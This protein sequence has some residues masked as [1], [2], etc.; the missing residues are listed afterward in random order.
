MQ[1]NYTTVWAMKLSDLVSKPLG[2]IM[3]T[4]GRVEKGMGAAEKKTQDVGKALG[5]AG[6]AANKLEAEYR[7]T[8]KAMRE[9]MDPAKVAAMQRKLEALGQAMG[10]VKDKAQG[11]R[12]RQELEAG[13]MS[14][15]GLARHMRH[16]QQAR[17]RAFDP[18]RIRAYNAELRQTQRLID[19]RNRMYGNGGG[20]GRMLAQ[21]MIQGQLYRAG[22][23]GQFAGQALFGGGAVTTGALVGGGIA[24]AGVGAGLLAV[25]GTRRAMAFE[26]TMGEA[27]A[28]MRLDR[29]S[30]KDL[31]SELL[32]VGAQNG[33]EQG[34]LG[35]A[36]TQI[37]SAVGDSRRAMDIMR[38]SAQMALAS[39]SDL[40]GVA[41]AMSALDAARGREGRST[42]NLADMLFAVQNKGRL[43]FADVAQY[44]PRSVGMD[45]GRF[46][47]AGSGAALAT[48]STSLPEET[49][50]MVYENLL[51]ALGR[52]EVLYGTRTDPGFAGS[53]I[54]VFDRAGR[55]RS[56]P[57]IIDAVA[58]RTRGMSTQRQTRFFDG[59]G[60]DSQASLAVK[61]LVANRGKLREFYDYVNNASMGLG[62]MKLAT[63]ASITTQ[64]KMNMALARLDEGLTRIGYK[65]L[66]LVDTVADGLT[67]K[68]DARLQ[69]AYRSGRFNPVTTSWMTQLLIR[70]FGRDPEAVRG[71]SPDEARQLATVGVKLPGLNAGAAGPLV[72][73]GVV[74]TTPAGL[75]G[76][77]K[78]DVPKQTAFSTTGGRYVYQTNH[79]KMEFKVEQGGM[80]LAQFRAQVADTLAL[81]AADAE[82]TIARED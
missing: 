22:L 76:G 16:L 46:G 35:G 2:N 69:E 54:N 58:G 7:R 49:A 71:V 62:E 73:P 28:T 23:P 25:N 37:V 20:A 81:A 80:S 75:S 52:K 51:T 82:I 57:D 45:A 53:G 6:S 5:Q 33:I 64:D 31:S 3:L 66:P 44:L 56:L 47:I 48:L 41:G 70:Y 40:G 39:K 79:F 19:Q 10:Q 72:G 50:A 24:A 34:Q 27:N 1:S 17:D 13:R 14:M 63:N 55:M 18:A 4:A 77:A 15:D 8:E 65:F 21:D 26:H 60:L 32:R 59:L 78:L 9:S 36:F 61:E 74:K 29:Q 67:G 12:F 30:L 43:S 42:Q 68:G 11:M 38:T